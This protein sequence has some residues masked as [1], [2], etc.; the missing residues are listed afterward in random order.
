[1]YMHTSGD[2]CI[3]YRIKL[4]SCSVIGGVGAVRLSGDIRAEVQRLY[5]VEVDH[6][7]Q[8]LRAKIHQEVFFSKKYIRVKTRNSYTVIYSQGGGEKYGIVQYFLSLSDQAVAVIQPLTVNTSPTC[9][10]SQL[11]ILH[12][13]IKPVVMDSVVCIVNVKNIIRKCVFVD[14]GSRV[15]V[16]TKPCRIAFD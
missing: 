10:P 9:Y 12:S 15:Y 2:H 13:R 6:A 8:F 1:M 14:T 5:G 7:S 16:C 3:L 11:S 4:S